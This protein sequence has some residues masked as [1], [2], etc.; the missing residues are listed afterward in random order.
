MSI[1]VPVLEK[2]FLFVSKLTKKESF[3]SLQRA[4]TQFFYWYPYQQCHP[5]HLACVFFTLFSVNVEEE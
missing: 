1:L 5:L 3:F 4:P 2:L